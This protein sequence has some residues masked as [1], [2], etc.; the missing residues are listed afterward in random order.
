MKVI[1][2]NLAKKLPQVLESVRSLSFWLQMAMLSESHAKQI[3]AGQVPKTACTS[4]T[5]PTQ[6]TYL[7]H[8]IS[9]I[10]SQP[11]LQVKTKPI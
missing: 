7:W 4:G 3:S 1:T 2:L 11:N 6:Y 10:H 5:V 9:T 8:R